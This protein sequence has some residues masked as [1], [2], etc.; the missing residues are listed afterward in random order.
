MLL[1]SPA[2]HL[3]DWFERQGRVYSWNDKCPEAAESFMPNNTGDGSGSLRYS[4]LP[5]IQHLPSNQNQ[6]PVEL[7]GCCRYSFLEDARVNDVG[8]LV[9]PS[10]PTFVVHS[11]MDELVPVA[12]CRQFCEDNAMSRG[13]NV[14]HYVELPPQDSRGDVLDHGLFNWAKED[15]A[16]DNCM[17]RVMKE[18]FILSDG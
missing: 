5:P 10:A 12:D 6:F 15:S 17:E 8:S 1:I 18:W 16:C 9:A 7:H 11:K 4:P 14:H 2:I 13:G 3:A